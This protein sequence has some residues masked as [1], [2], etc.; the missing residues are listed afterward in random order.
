MIVKGAHLYWDS[1]KPCISVTCEQCFHNIPARDVFKGKCTQCGNT[2]IH[3][4]N[5]M[6]SRLFA[7]FEAHFPNNNYETREGFGTHQL[8]LHFFQSCLPVSVNTASEVFKY[9]YETTHNAIETKRIK[10][11]TKKT[12]PV[13]MN[14]LK[15]VFVQSQN[16]NQT[17]V[18]VNFETV[19]E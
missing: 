3:V 4:S 10:K 7:S 19:F 5:A 11:I 14:R 16:N 9:I 18:Y 1:T 8:S 6:Y 15:I 17:P 2:N 12:K 13:I